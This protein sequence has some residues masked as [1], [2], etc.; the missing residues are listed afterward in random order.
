MS[1]NDRYAESF[2]PLVYGDTEA[3]VRE[4][5]QQFSIGS[6]P[7][8]L[9]DSERRATTWSSIWMIAAH[10][11]S[12][13]PSAADI[14]A[15]DPVA[16]DLALWEPRAGRE[17]ALA[18]DERQFF[19]HYGISPAHS[20]KTLSR[21]A[22]AKIGGAV[23]HINQH[24]P[25]GTSVG[26]LFCKPL[27]ELAT[28]PEIVGRVTS[29]LGD[30]VTCVGT[31]GP[32][33][34]APNTKGTEWHFAGGRDFGGENDAGLDLVTVWLALSDVPR[35][36][37]P[38]KMLTRSFPGNLALYRRE[39]EVFGPVSTTPPVASADDGDP[40]DAYLADALTGLERLPFR[41]SEETMK[42]IVAR[43]FNSRRIPDLQFVHDGAPRYNA[44]HTRIDVLMTVGPD[45]LPTCLASTWSR[46]R[47]KPGPS[48]C[49]PR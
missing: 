30:D 38:M 43:R 41:T 18:E 14:Y 12:D 49:S 5:E 35:E 34:I 45:A 2:G 8:L 22:L 31:S 36:R 13:P 39:K 10:R 19:A 20:L 46:W 4:L 42:K 48:T 44:F 11:A 24:G 25:T 21:N 47:L 32:M 9:L 3:F 26:Y 6:S 27:F 37:A 7:D 29:L 15:N 28:N 17:H 40:I 1:I 23:G 33:Y 16:C